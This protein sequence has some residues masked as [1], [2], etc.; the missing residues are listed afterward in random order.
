MKSM[1]I[2]RKER[3]LSG[4]YLALSRR[5]QV[6]VHHVLSTV[7][8]SLHSRTKRSGGI[9]AE[10]KKIRKLELIRIARQAGC[11]ELDKEMHRS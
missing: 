8:G 10:K 9:R 5:G 11:D 6:G 3:R 4:R 2:E 1:R 7:Q